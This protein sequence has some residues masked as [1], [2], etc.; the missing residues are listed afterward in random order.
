MGHILYTLR[1]K[2]GKDKVVDLRLGFRPGGVHGRIVEH[3]RHGRD[4]GRGSSSDKRL[5][6]EG[7]TAR[8]LPGRC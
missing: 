4:C 8:K 6:L 5:P 3:R 1:F 7:Y 2:N